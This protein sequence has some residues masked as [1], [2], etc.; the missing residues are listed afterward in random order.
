VR[1]LKTV[2]VA[3]EAVPRLAGYAPGTLSYGFA[4]EK[5]AGGHIFQLNFSNTTGTTVGQ[6]ARGGIR[7]SLYLGFNITEVL[8]RPLTDRRSR[9]TRRRHCAPTNFRPRG[10]AVARGRLLR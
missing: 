2:Y 9:R 5:L 10:L 7:D 1:V 8:L 3:A 6:L 4:V